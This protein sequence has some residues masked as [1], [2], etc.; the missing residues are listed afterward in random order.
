MF[1][2]SCGSKG[3]H[4]NQFCRSCG[5]DLDIV[6]KMIENPSSVKGLAVSPRDEIGRAFAQK[7]RDSNSPS[8]LAELVEDSLPEIKKLLE[9]SEEKRLR[10]M[11]K[12]T[13]ISSSGLGVTLMYLL[14]ILN[15]S[16]APSIM[17]VGLGLIAFLIGLGFII[18]GLFFTSPENPYLE[19][20]SKTQD[21]V[22]GSSADTNDLLMP[23]TAQREFSSVTENTTRHL[24]NKKPI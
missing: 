15:G 21:K 19:K 1:C 2:P 5:M 24:K 6:Q 14:M 22:E 4:S 11:R 12:G 9:S 7:I 10:R 16:G 8:E 20:E 23:P 13:I 18:N 17:M 3:N